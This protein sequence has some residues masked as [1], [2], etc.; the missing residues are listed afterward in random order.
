VGV[1]VVGLFIAGVSLSRF[2]RVMPTLVEVP[3]ASVRAGGVPRDV[4]V[5]RIR[6]LIE[7]DRL[8][9]REALFYR[10]V[11]AEPQDANAVSG[12]GD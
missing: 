12:A 8:S 1:V 3:A 11:G 6:A 7:Q 5:G 2:Q 9:D 4:D 10:E